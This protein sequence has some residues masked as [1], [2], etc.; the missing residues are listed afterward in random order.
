MNQFITAYSLIRP[1]RIEVNGRSEYHDEN[2]ITFAEFIKPFF[3]RLNLGYS[4]FYKMDS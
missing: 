2:F 3:K 1:F 4:K